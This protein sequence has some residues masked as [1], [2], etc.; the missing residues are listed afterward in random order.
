MPTS[1]GLASATTSRVGGVLQAAGLLFFAFAGYA[2]IATLGEEVRDPA[3]T[4][5]R[6]IP[7][8]L[9]ITLVVYAR[10]RGRGAGRIGQRRT[11]LRRRRRSPTRC[12]PRA[13]RPRAG[14]A[15]G[16]RGGGARL[17]AGADPRGLPHDAGDGARPSSAARAGRGAPAVRQPA[18]RRG[19]GRR[20]GGR[21]RRRW[22]TCAARS[23]SRRSRCCCTTRSPTPRRGRWSRKAGDIQSGRRVIRPSGWRAACCSRSRCR[24]RRLIA[25]SGVVVV[26]AVAYGL[27]AWRS[28]DMDNWSTRRP[29]TTSS[30]RRT[31]G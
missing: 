30:S 6:A 20:R 31:N 14:G 25:G 4:I 11:W 2:R 27:R 29:D 17:T 19:R 28:A 1:R 10:G 16:R 15:G 23:A 21:R 9:G 7:I 12:A 13:S 5:P 24:C 18:P 22:S 8:A 26:G 3:R